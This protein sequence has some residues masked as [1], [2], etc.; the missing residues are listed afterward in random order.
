M[1]YPRLVTGGLVLL[2]FAGVGL[3]MR[4]VWPAAPVWSAWTTAMAAAATVVF[5][6]E[7]ARR[8]QDRALRDAA[9]VLRWLAAGKFGHKLYA[10][11]SPALADLARATNAAAESIAERI[12]RLE[13]DRRQLSAVLGGMVEGVV[14]L[15]GRQTVLFAN[16]RAGRL[17]DFDP[18]QAVGR[19]FWEVVRSRRLQQIVG[20][21]LTGTDPV[22]E[23]L[24]WPG[25]PF[26]RLALYAARLGGPQRGAV[27]VIHD[28]TDL[29][30]LE[31]V[32]QEFVANVSHEL[33]TPLAVIKASVETL[34]AGAA[35]DAEARDG[36]L[37][38]IDEQSDRLHNLIL[39]LLNL[40]RIE[41]GAATLDVRPVAVTDAVEHCLARHRPRAKTKGLRL[42]AI[43][44]NE[45]VAV[46]ADDEALDTLLENLVD[47]ALKYTAVGHVAVRW[48]AADGAAR[49]EVEDT[50]VGIPER[51]LPRLF[52][53]FYRVDKARSR[54]L[55]G[56]G[57]GLSIVKHLVQSMGGDVSVRSSVGR[58]SVFVVQLPTAE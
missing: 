18:P 42:E 52:E 30:R 54:E 44:P 6:V 53:R 57:L 49:L 3:G 31:Q 40:A 7:S 25:P 9:E 38:Q 29:R 2:V 55:G 1:P 33:K 21:S 11:G 17:L 10:G 36:F 24:G 5:V 41:S 50:G 15:D 20:E 19:P 8:R 51:D 45:P 43:P 22:R 12:G 47:N 16:D 34:I 27:V 58:G 14:A 4:A 37:T 23:E 26:R 48:Q 39:D 56:T 28:V 32:R 46:L 13:D 35:D